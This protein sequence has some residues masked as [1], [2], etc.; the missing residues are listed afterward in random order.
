MLETSDTFK[1]IAA[2]RASMPLSRF[3]KA[4]EMTFDVIKI[5]NS[6]NVLLP[7]QRSASHS[8]TVTLK[9]REP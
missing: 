6:D 2:A 8:P 5:R 7:C 3:R 4:N 1:G 9:A